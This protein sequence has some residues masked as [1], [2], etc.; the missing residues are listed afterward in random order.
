MFL[1]VLREVEGDLFN[2]PKDY[3]LAHCVGS[4]LGMR[5]GIAVRFRFVIID[6]IF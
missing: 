4:D 2:A 5:A 3:A 1:F 6:F